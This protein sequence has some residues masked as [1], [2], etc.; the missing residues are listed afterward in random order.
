VTRDLTDEQAGTL[1]P[2]QNRRLAAMRPGEALE[3]SSAALTRI[4]FKPVTVDPAFGLVQGQADKVMV[5]E[6]RRAVRAI[7]KAKLPLPGKP[8]HQ[9]TRALIVVRPDGAGAA[10]HAE[11]ITTIWDS[12]GDSRTAMETEPAI[13]ESFFQAVMQPDMASAPNR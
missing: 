2:V 1:A 13:Y 9:A 5:E 12:N 3:A 6:W 7:L 10:L 4:G 8:D 11:F